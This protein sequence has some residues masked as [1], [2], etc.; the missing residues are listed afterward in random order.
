MLMK[1]AIFL[2][3]MLCLFIALQG[4]TEM[5]G[6]LTREAILRGLPEWQKVMAS[7]QPDPLAVDKLKA[8]SQPVQIEIFL[9]TWC[10]DSK[11]HVS[12][13]FKVLDL[14]DNPLLSASYIG[15]PRDKAK[16]ADYLQGKD[17][18]KIPTFIVTV[19]GREKG[20]IIET[21]LKSIEQD[22]VELISL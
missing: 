4:Q 8:I 16:R 14:A 1:K 5:L 22:L 17:I 6:P 12:E 7:Y 9:G 21:P 2:I 11:A 15:L 18:R 3:S 13:F 10:P 19:G 20:R